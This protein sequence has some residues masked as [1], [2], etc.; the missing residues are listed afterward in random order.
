MGGAPVAAPCNP[1]TTCIASFAPVKVLTQPTPLPTAK[2]SVF[3]FED[4]LPL[5]GENDA[6]GQV[7]DNQ[8][9]T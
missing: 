5:N 2:L 3:V 7:A 4:D 9:G 6:G 8:L 1:G